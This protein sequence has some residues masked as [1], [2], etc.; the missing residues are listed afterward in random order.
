MQVQE[1]ASSL[2]NAS[3]WGSLKVQSAEG[4]R[5]ELIG[6]ALG[7][8][9][10]VERIEVVAGGAVVASTAPSLPRPEIASEF[11]DREAAARCGFQVVI[12]A[13]GKGLSILDVRAALSDGTAAPMGQLRV[14]A[15]PRRWSGVFRRS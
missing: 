5:L 6:W 4:S 7:A 15:P 11:P 2:P 8:S 14:L 3:L 9:A 13:R 12:E 10:D 1:L